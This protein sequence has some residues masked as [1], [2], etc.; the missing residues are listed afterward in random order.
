MTPPAMHSGNQ[1]WLISWVSELTAASL[2]QVPLLPRH[3]S[4]RFRGNSLSLD[5]CEELAEEYNL[6]IATSMTDLSALRGLNHG[7]R[8][9]PVII[10]FH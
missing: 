7:M 8:D 2:C 9:L 6:M 1:I 3:I 10:S 4:W 5:H